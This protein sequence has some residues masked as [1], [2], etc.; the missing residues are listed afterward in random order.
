MRPPLL[1]K[2]SRSPGRWAHSSKPAT[3]AA[4]WDRQTDGHS[5]F[6]ITLHTHTHTHT[7][8]RLMALCPGLPGWASTRMVKPMWILLKQETVSGSDISWAICKSAPRSTQIT[9]PAPH[10]PVFYRPD[11]LPAAQPTA[12]KH[13]RNNFT[14][15][16]IYSGFQKGATIVYVFK[17][18][19]SQALIEK[20]RWTNWFNQ[21]LS[22]QQSALKPPKW[23][24]PVCLAAVNIS[25][26]NWNYIHFD[27]HT[28]MHTHPPNQQR[29][30]TEGTIIPGYYSLTVLSPS[31]PWVLLFT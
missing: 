7:H 22:S 4:R 16:K 28:Q 12:S 8:T 6:L 3:A 11:A 9:T 2:Q 5:L 19:N 26:Y 20:K 21:L 24:R 25:S 29:Q 30:S 14:R 13:W 17:K 1:Q 18:N 27:N 31:V 10:Q 15:R 23:R